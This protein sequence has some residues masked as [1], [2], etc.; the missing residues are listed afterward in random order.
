[1]TER[2]NLMRIK[3]KVIN[4]KVKPITSI[5]KITHTTEKRD[6]RIPNNNRLCYQKK[7]NNTGLTKESLLKELV[8][9]QN[10]R[11]FDHDTPDY[12]LPICILVDKVLSTNLDQYYWW[13]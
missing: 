5:K 7:K 6:P 3:D 13:K 2:Y 12:E 1:M 11:T 9:I 8:T 10:D 4:T